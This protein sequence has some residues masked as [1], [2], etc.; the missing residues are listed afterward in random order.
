MK[1]SSLLLIAT[2]ILISVNTFA[3]FT[4]TWIGSGETQRPTREG[5]CKDVE[6]RLI[7]TQK[8]LTLRGGH[9]NCDGISAEYPYS[10]FSIRDGKLYE[11]E[12]FVGEITDKKI[13][14]VSPAD[15]YEL[16]FNLYKGK[17]YLVE[18]WIDGDDYLIIG[19]ELT[20]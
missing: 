11:R 2:I 6:I 13:K 3:D 9:Y 8:K 1:N 16:N 15:G 17:L 20:K 7:Q 5:S 19:A 10:V 14:L 18:S 4:G 12:K